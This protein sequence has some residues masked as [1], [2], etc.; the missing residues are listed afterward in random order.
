MP[1]IYR[2]RVVWVDL[3]YGEKPFLI[4][5][6]NARN[7]ALDDFLAVRITTSAPR[8]PRPTMVQLAS[9]DPLVGW[10]NC[11]DLTPIYRDEIRREAGSLSVSTMMGVALGLKAAL[12]IL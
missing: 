6:N 11:D 12:G 8:A 1:D 5:S 4:V 9:H 7:N 2:G 3:N 10:V